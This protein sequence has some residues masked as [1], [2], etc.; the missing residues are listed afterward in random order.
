[1]KY[2]INLN[3]RALYELTP[4][5]KLVEAVIL[6]YL[7]MLCREQNEKIE[8]QR[9]NGYTWVDYKYLLKD[10]PLLKG[11]TPATLTPKIK[12]LKELGYIETFIQ[13]SRK[14]VKLTTLCESLF[15]NL[16]A[17]IKKTK[18]AHLEN[19]TYNNTIDNNT[20]IINSQQIKKEKNDFLEVKKEILNHEH[21][22]DIKKRFPNRDYEY[23]IKKMVNWWS[24]HNRIIK[25]PF[26]AFTNWIENTKPDIGLIKQIEADLAQEKLERIRLEYENNK[27]TPEGAAKKIAEGRRIL[28]KKIAM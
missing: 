9:I 11:R 27:A 10:M 16:N 4:K 25:R 22:E 20:K 8:E 12:K 18:R 15:R 2:N 24:E 17:P 13:D 21:W 14:F 19:L 23:Q 6:D 28:A 5:I 3:Q 26:S 1:M 7:I